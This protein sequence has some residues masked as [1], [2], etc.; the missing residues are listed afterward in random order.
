MIATGGP[1]RIALGDLK[2]TWVTI[3]Y[4]CGM[5]FISERIAAYGKR[6]AGR[7]LI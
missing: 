5:Y 6:F 1:I 2:Y 7:E 4:I 3:V